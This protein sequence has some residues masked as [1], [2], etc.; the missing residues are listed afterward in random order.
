MPRVDLAQAIL[1]RP[2][3]SSDQHWQAIL[4]DEA[5]STRVDRIVKSRCYYVI[6][7]YN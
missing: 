5:G 1:F 4:G 2:S 3:G 7:L 6:R